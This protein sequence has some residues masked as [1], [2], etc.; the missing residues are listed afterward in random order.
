M[1]TPKIALVHDYWV[2]LRGGERVFLGLSRL[3]PHADCFVLVAPG[4][5]LPDTMAQ[6]PVR[7]SFLSY[8][9]RST[10]Y[11][12]AYLPLYPAAARSLHLRGYDLVISSSSGFTHHVRS[13]G[14][15]ICYCHTPLRYAWQEIDETLAA[16]RSPLI[17]ATLRQM[18]GSIRRADVVAAQKVTGYLANSQ[19]VQQRIAQY[20]GRE[21]LVVHPFVDIERFTPQEK[22]GKYLLVVSQLHA[23]KRVDV[24]VR[25]CTQLGLPL[26]VVGVGPELDHLKSLAGPT[27]RFA[28][29]VGEDDLPGL[30]ARAIALL[31]CGEEDFGIAALEAQASG[32]PVV[33]LGRGGALETIRSGTTG[34]YFAE[35]TTE[36]VMAVIQQTQTTTWSAD[37]LRTHAATFDE[38]HF[39]QNIMESLA[40]LLPSA[41]VSQLAAQIS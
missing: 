31:Q 23:Y 8:L 9:P 35:P 11:Y 15:H 24:A 18:L 2:T 37:V 36:S 22:P 40:A 26:I 7:R 25:A 6:L 27:V 13:S 33:A 29:R 1:S 39:R 19:T 3:F 21:S 28:G 12:R 14:A 20:Y 16:Y 41:L 5:G 4:K 17:R 10:R 34:L 32:R 38:A 30:Y